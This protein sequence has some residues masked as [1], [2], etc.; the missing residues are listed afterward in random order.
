MENAELVRHEA[1]QIRCCVKTQ[2]RVGVAVGN[3]DQWISLHKTLRFLL[4]DE[5]KG[6][7]LDSKQGSVLCFIL[8]RCRYSIFLILEM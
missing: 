4:R 8:Q 2:M 3:V 1:M 5:N 7:I 6:L